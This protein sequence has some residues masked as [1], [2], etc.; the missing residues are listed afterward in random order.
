MRGGDAEQAVKFTLSFSEILGQGGVAQLVSSPADADGPSQQISDLWGD[1]RIAAINR[2]LDIAQD[3]GEA[4]L[5]RCRYIL[6]SGIA[7]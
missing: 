6:L 4:D 2:I 1:D 5:M 7:I 3:M